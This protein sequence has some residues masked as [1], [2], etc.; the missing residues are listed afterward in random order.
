[1]EHS[2]LFYQQ[3]SKDGYEL[4]E[5]LITHYAYTPG[6]PECCRNLQDYVSHSSSSILKCSDFSYSGGYYFG[7]YQTSV[8]PEL[9]DVNRNNLYHSAY[10]AARLI[11]HTALHNTLT[12]VHH[13]KIP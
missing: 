13:R 7:G 6:S 4:V 12:H 1:M 3:T 11:K 5:A 2:P 9:D 10:L 8:S